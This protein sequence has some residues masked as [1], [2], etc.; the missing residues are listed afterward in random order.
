MKLADVMS[1]LRL[2]GY[3]EAAFIL[4]AAAFLTVLVTTFMRRNREPFEHARW[5]PLA[6]DRP[7]AR[8]DRDE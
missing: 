8:G 5:L 3:A 7:A 4:A 1:Q 2:E 6:D